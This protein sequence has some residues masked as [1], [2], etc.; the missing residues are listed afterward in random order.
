MGI[1]VRPFKASDISTFVPIEPMTRRDRPNPELAEAIEKSNLAVTGIRNGK[2]VLYGGVHP[3]PTEGQG[4]LWLCLSKTC[5][6]HKIATLRLL[7]D[8]LKIVEEVF[9]FAQL[10]AIIRYDFAPSIKLIKHLGFVL[11]QTK[12]KWLVFSKRVKK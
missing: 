1:Y 11:T 8:G 2:I 10:N 12:G 6:K 5:L 7:K 9:P 3:A 4:E